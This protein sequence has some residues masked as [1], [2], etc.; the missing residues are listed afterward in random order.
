[1]SPLTV[2]KEILDLKEKS[3]NL[4]RIKTTRKRNPKLI[5]KI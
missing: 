2:P 1:V 3:L 5:N 4:I